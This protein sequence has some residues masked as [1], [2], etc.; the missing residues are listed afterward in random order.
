MF[1]TKNV[2][3]KPKN[4]TSSIIGQVEGG[5]GWADSEAGEELL[6][7]DEDLL[8]KKDDKEGIIVLDKIDNSK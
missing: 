2:V 7:S 1:E 3:D 5:G 8:D 4:I 6:L